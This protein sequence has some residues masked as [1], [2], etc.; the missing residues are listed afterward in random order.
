MDRC[1]QRLLMAAGM[2]V[3]I[4]AWS[5]AGCGAG[6][7]RPAGGK[8]AAEKPK[9]PELRPGELKLSTE[10]VVVF[11]D[12]YCLVVKRATGTPGAD[13]ELF[14]EQV[15]DAAILGSFWAVP[16]EGRLLGMTAGMVTTTEKTAKPALC[17]QHLEILKV[18][19][20]K[21][22][23]VELQDKAVFKGTIREVL[24]EETKVPASP[25]AAEPAATPWASDL[26]RFR[27]S[28]TYSIHR[29]AEPAP[30]ATATALSGSL[31]VLA[32]AEGDVL[33]PVGQVRSLTIKGMTV[34]DD[35]TVT[36]EKT[37][38]RLT[39]RFDQP[40]GQRELLIMYFCPGI[41]WI[42]TYRIELVPE[43]KE[44][45]LAKLDLQAE[46]LNECE[47][48]VDVPVDLVVGVPNFRFKGVVSPF[49][50]EGVLRNA[51]QQAAPQ[52]MGQYDGNMFSNALFSQRSGEWRRP[53]TQE[54]APPPAPAGGS[55]ELPAELT[56]AGSQDLFI[57]SLNKLSLPKGHRA[58]VPI[59]QATAPYRNVRTWDVHLQRRDVETAPAGT[60]VASPLVLSANQ[61]WHQVEL[62]N[63]TKVPW[64]TGA[65]MLMQG[66]RPLA[67]ELLTYTS[68]GGAV[69][70]PVTVSVDV[71]GTF[72]EKET[73][74]QL[75]ALKWLGWTY[76]RIEK[77]ATLVLDNRKGI[78]LDTEVACRFG[79]HAD[80]AS[81]GGAISIGSFDSTDWYDYHGHAEVN[82]R[83]LVAW[84]LKIE[85]GKTTV[86]K[87]KYH[88]FARQY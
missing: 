17:L 63:N 29:P 84:S 32:T 38:K 15:P 73:D 87:V 67:Q 47:D 11:K 60:A 39:F 75:N 14:T 21:E 42:P 49:S 13:G 72:S 48:L 36:T 34:T 64:T 23:T 56:A 65:A 52:L 68:P 66:G 86:L 22:C 69:R 53:V 6:E 20:G 27:S 70:V 31:F 43:E 85:A 33:L 28:V 30:K 12:G 44:E 5:A 80:Q 58:A 9:P 26:S 51:L 50:L 10:R 83:S 40:E 1:N 55:V 77:E 2:V 37:A 25:A 57:Y 59:F 7:P 62:T 16:K 41:R 18:N 76:A 46:I 79:G 45:K 35:R 74:R 19:K 3:A 24:A 4:I 82:N 8:A 54:Q 78:P 81:D 88:Y 71:R 61:V